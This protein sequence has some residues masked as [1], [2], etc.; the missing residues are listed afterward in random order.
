MNET[1][2]LLEQLRAVAIPALASNPNGGQRFPGVLASP[3]ELATA[4]GARP[5][6]PPET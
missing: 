6:R 2:I 5:D 3:R 4:G 1:S